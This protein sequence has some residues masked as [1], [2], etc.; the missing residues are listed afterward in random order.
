MEIKLVEGFAITFCLPMWINLVP[1]MVY[2]ISGRF[3][4]E[5]PNF[6]S[7]TVTKNGTMRVAHTYQ[8]SSPCAHCFRRA[9]LA[10]PFSYFLRCLSHFRLLRCWCPLHPQVALLAKCRAS[11]TLGPPKYSLVR[12]AENE[13]GPGEDTFVLIVCPFSD[14]LRV[15]PY[16]VA[17]SCSNFS[18]LGILGV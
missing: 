2:F 16:K 13:V 6:I 8:S 14:S 11:H 18:E 12:H 3:K 9:F 17:S 5:N 10:T 15:G 1:G 7:I 4:F